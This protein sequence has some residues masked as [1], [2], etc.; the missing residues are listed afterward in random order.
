MISFAFDIYLRGF[1]NSQTL[2]IFSTENISKLSSP[3]LASFPGSGPPE[4]AF[5]YEDEPEESMISQLHR[6]AAHT[7]MPSR[8]SWSPAQD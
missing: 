6:A 5:D 7:A 8:V 3:G 1:N 2:I 4:P